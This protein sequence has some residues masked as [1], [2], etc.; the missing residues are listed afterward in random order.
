MYIS[1]PQTT[2]LLKSL[3]GFEVSRE[4][5]DQAGDAVLP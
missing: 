5:R 4:V 1:E 2:L 3:H